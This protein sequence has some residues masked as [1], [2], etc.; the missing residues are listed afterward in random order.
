[1]RIFGADVV[2]GAHPSRSPLRFGVFEVDFKAGELRKQ[3]AKVKLQDQPFQVLTL[4]L[5]HPGDLVSRDN[6]RR[7]IWPADTFVDFDQGLNNAI[8]RLRE[9]LGDNP[10]HPQYIETIPKRG[11]RFIGSLDKCV[12]RIRSLAVLPLVNLPHDPEEEYFAEGL[13]EALITMLATIGEL[14]L[15]SRTSVMQYQGVRKPLSEIARELGVDAIVEGTVFRVGDR[16]RI[17]AQLIETPLETH[18]WAESYE[19]DL[20]DILALQAEVAKAIARQV[21]VKLTPQEQAQLTELRSVDPRA[22]EA[23][24]RGR[25]HW[26]RRSRGGLGKAVQ[27]FQEA[28]SIDQGCAVAYTGLADCLA[29][30][31]WWGYVSPQEGCGKGKGL[32]TEALKQDHGL[33]EAHASSGWIKAFFDF[34]FPAAERSFERALEI[35]P[36]YA[37]AHLW[38]GFF[39]SLMGR[40]EEGWTE[41]K[42]AIRLDPQSIVNQCLGFLLLF[43]R[44]YDEA[45]AEFQEALDLDPS[46]APAH[47]GLCATYAFKA[48][49][50]DAIDAGQKAVKLSAGGTLFVAVLGEAYAAAGY[51]QEANDIIAQLQDGSKQKYVSPYVVGRIYAAMDKRK[52]A[53]DCLETSYREHV[54]HTLLIKTDPRLD[55][56]RSEPRFADLLRCMKFPK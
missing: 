24:L 56:L 16:V 15:I 47:W 20:R 52:D 44:R 55:N 3:G 29:V 1:M 51:Q 23:Y 39:L 38:F 22:Y 28:I 27:F 5:E 33:A 7:G 12:R 4:L 40:H 19:R 6:L 46:F 49:H 13:T 41:V 8:K 30:L 21:E 26:N 54:P 14:R 50:D 32:V 45:I 42:R 48:L 17:T 25:Y 31:G 10:E 36:R 11:Y 37:T 53:L 34:D 9:A 18:L 2:N 35:N 43:A